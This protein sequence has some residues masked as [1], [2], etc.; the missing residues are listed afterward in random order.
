M[1]RLAIGAIAFCLV[2]GANAAAQVQEKAYTETT[3]KKTGPGPDVKTKAE[4]V[5]GTVKEYE[6][7]KKIK[8]SGPGDK[9]YS[10]DL[11]EGARVE[12]SILIGQKAKV[13]YHKQSDGTEHVAVISEA[14]H[15]AQSAENAPKLHSETTVKRTGPGPDT[16]S[17]SEVVIGTVKEYEPGKKIKVT[18]PENKDYSFDLDEQVAMIGTV[19]VGERVKVTYTRTAD[20]RKVTTLEPYRK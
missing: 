10:F 6:P 9:T 18:G 5:V 2:V 13:S 14:S 15:S 8:I 7:G 1:K 12:G 17:K 11:D 16:K 20:G 4:T 19:A 3:T